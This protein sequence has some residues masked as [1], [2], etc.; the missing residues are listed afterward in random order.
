M[1]DSKC[2]LAR[3]VA[4][5]ARNRSTGRVRT[6][7]MVVPWQWKRREVCDRFRKAHPRDSVRIIE[8]GATGYGTSDELWV[9]PSSAWITDD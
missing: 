3:I 4:L 5:S 1:T 9:P 2:H 7:R 8:W 6:F